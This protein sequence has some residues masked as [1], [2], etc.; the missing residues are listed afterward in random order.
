MFVPCNNEISFDLHGTF[1]DSIVRL[2][3]QEMKMRLGSYY[4][5]DFGNG[6]QELRDSVFLPAKFLLELL[7]CLLENSDR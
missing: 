3:S 4:G 1:E 7:G 6:F 2:I 5:S